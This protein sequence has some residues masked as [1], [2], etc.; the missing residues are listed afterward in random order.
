MTLRTRC[1]RWNWM[2][3]HW[4]DKTNNW[5]KDVNITNVWQSPH[6]LKCF[7][8]EV[9]QLCEQ[10]RRAWAL[11]VADPGGKIW[12]CLP[13]NLAIHFGPLQQR[14]K[15]ELQGNILNWPIAKSRDPPYDVA[16]SRVSWCA[17][18]CIA[19]FSLTK[20]RITLYPVCCIPIYIIILYVEILFYCL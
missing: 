7:Q 12:Q 16:P 13:S 2:A 1:Y 15:R 9:T 18:G 3:I 6:D 11:A 19:I 17:T 4:K 10:N 14:N 8:F 20:T 5:R